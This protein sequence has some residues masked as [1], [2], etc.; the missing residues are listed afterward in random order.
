MSTPTIP[1]RNHGRWQLRRGSRRLVWGTVNCGGS[2]AGRWR[3]PWSI[4]Q[5]LKYKYNSILSIH[6]TG[7]Y[8][9]VS[10]SIRHIQQTSRHT[11][12]DM[13]FQF[14]REWQRATAPSNV[15]LRRAERKQMA[16]T[17][18][19]SLEALSTTTSSARMMPESENGGLLT[20]HDFLKSL[21]LH[22]LRINNLRFRLYVMFYT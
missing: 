19:N 4:T 17:E 10:T 8:A 16:H 21:I 6:N 1:A 15:S 11:N 5:S 3:E 12:R 20:L 14:L 9:G 7:R 18:N 2:P 13:K 22:R